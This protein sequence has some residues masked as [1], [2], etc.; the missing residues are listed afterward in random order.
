MLAVLSVTVKFSVA[1]EP[2]PPSAT[3][4]EEID[5][6]GRPSLILIVCDGLGEGIPIDFLAPP[7]GV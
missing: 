5:S 4:G 1:I 7:M 2:A 6:V 3:F